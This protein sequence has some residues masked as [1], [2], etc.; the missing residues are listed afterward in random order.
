MK[1]TFCLL[2]SLVLLLGVLP[3][4]ALAAT[5]PQKEGKV[6]LVSTADEL[7]WVAEQVNTG[8][9]TAIQVRLTAAITLPQTWPGIGTEEH[10]FAGTF[11]GG[12]KKVTLNDSSWGLFG[13]VMGQPGAVATIKNVI[14]EGQVKNS[15]IAASAGYAHINRCINRAAVKANS[16][17]VG[18]ILGAVDYITNAGVHHT[19]VRIT[20]CGNEGT[21]EAL[22]DTG[23]ILGYTDCGTIISRCYNTGAIKGA[24]YTGGIVGSMQNQNDGGQVEYSY[25]TGKVEGGQRTGG[26]IGN[27]M[28][29]VT[30]SYCYNSGEA[31]YAFAGHRFNYT[32]A[33]GDGCFFLGVNSSKC[34]PDATETLHHNSTSYEISTRA[35]AKSAADMATAAFAGALGSNFKQ[36]CPTPVLTWQ[37]AKDHTGE[38]VCSD[39]KLGSTAKE[40]YNISYQQHTAFTLSGPATVV[41][42]DSLTVTLTLKEGYKRNSLFAVKANGAKLTE[43]GEGTFVAEDVS[44]PLSITVMGV[45]LR[46]E[47][48]NIKWSDVG[49]GYR[50]K[51]SDVGNGY[52]I[53]GDAHVPENEDYSFLINFE[54]GFQPAKGLFKVQAVE[55]VDEDLLKQGA[56]PDVKTLEQD[57]GG[58]Y[59]IESVNSDYRIVVSGVGTTSDKTVTVN[60]RVSEGYYKLHTSDNSARMMAGIELEVPYFDLGLY[61]LEKYYYNPNC[62]MTDG[63]VNGI[64]QVGNPELANENITVMHAFIVATERFRMGYS[65]EEV[66]KALHRTVYTDYINAFNTLDQSQTKVSWSQDVGSSFMNFWTHGTN[67]NYYVNYVYPLGAPSWGSTSDQIL[68]EDGDDLSIHLITGTGSGSRFGVFTVND[69]YKEF[70][71][72]TARDEY[73]VQQGQKVNLTLYW[74]GNGPQYSTVYDLQPGKKIYWIR[75][76]NAT[77]DIRQ[78][79]KTELGKVQQPSEGWEDEEN[80]EDEMKWEDIPT[81]LVTGSNGTVTIDTSFAAPGVYYLAAPGGFSSKGAM[82]ADDETSAAE[83]GLALFKLE[84]KASSVDGIL[85]DVDGSGT[86]TAE[87]ATK[88]LRVALKLEDGISLSVADVDGSKTITAEDATCILRRALKLIDSF[89]VENN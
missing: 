29:N 45:Q 18:G 50:I 39:C 76:E 19:E 36:S 79:N 47:A 69:Q 41:Q 83:A 58:F 46:K 12:G 61:G 2:L 33:F 64:Q 27:M 57:L 49:N 26:I 77:S 14:T 4:S 43:S 28:N 65:Q 37:A 8:S 74:T 9:N 24:S 82:N 21:I 53:Q 5:A 15:P 89:P 67:L 7:N 55:I 48:Y 80:G 1:K 16:D 71:Q 22:S 34:S 17:K 88:V 38:S 20:E 73:A 66:G 81:A 85:G 40:R 32:S 87:D 56:Q 52:R 62:Y 63:V 13:F 31:Y 35:I 23:G 72:N 78:W 6:Y 42:G 59:R 11:D 10:K 70:S 75:E 86:I 3:V 84:V 25:N 68:L 60:F 44:G 30:I 54:P 51:G